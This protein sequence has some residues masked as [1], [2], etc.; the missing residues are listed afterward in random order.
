MAGIIP[1]VLHCDTGKSKCLGPMMTLG[2]NLTH[3]RVKARTVFY[4]SQQT[5]TSFIFTVTELVHASGS[6]VFKRE[7]QA[8]S[9]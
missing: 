3:V 4:F 2:S 9:A 5:K 8:I 7:F 6:V 1:H